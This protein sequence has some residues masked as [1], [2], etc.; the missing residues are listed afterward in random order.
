[1]KK[2]WFI[3]MIMGFIGF[4]FTKGLDHTNFLIVTWASIILIS[5]DKGVES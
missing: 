3:T 1:M 2:I 4:I 5:L